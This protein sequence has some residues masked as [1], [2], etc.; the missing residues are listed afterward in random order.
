MSSNIGIVKTCEFCNNEFIAKK[1]TT[2]CCSDPCAKRFY[3]LKKRNDKI[4][5][6]QLK[7]EIKRKPKLFYTEDE[8]KAINAKQNLTLNEAAFVLNVSPLTLRRWTLHDNRMNASK[9]GKK[10][11]FKK[12]LITTVI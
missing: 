6:A 8:I 9:N 10:W 11:I 12:L 1:T 3:K 2:Q 5:Q 4:A 7:I